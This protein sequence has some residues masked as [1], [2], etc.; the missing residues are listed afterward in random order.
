MGLVEEGQNL[1]ARFELGDASSNSFD[2]ACAIGTW[3][4]V[5]L[6]REGILALDKIKGSTFKRH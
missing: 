1:I 6:G 4:D 5:V 3:Y 2:G